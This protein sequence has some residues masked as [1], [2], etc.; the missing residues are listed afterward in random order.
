M[1]HALLALHQFKLHEMNQYQFRQMQAVT[2]HSSEPFS[3]VFAAEQK[4]SAVFQQESQ[5]LD[6]YTRE[7]IQAHF[8]NMQN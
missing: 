3:S 1:L 7:I 4:S 6:V 5:I 8:E 2:H